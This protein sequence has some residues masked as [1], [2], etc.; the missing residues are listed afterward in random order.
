MTSMFPIAIFGLSA[1]ETYHDLV[2]VGDH[3][4]MGSSSGTN[5]K[6][7]NTHKKNFSI[8]NEGT[9]NIGGHKD[10]GTTFFNAYGTL[11]TDLNRAISNENLRIPTLS[12]KG[13]LAK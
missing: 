1:E 11:K 7:V 12:E 13:E 10:N 9:A 6:Y 5:H 8:K 4:I 2:K 3:P